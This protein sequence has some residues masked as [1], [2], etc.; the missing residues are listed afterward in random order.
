VIIAKPKVTMP[1]N[2]A[3][4]LTHV[5]PIKKPT[6]AENKPPIKMPIMGGTFRF[7]AS[8]DEVNPPIPKNAACPRE[9]CPEVANKFQL[10]AY[11][12]K[13]AIKVKTRI[14]KESLR[15]RGTIRENNM[16]A[17]KT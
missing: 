2:H 14:D 9:P 4:S 6:P 12:V 3:F 10:E 8:N 13:R 17:T 16:E 1:K 15:K 7:R 11:I 5:R